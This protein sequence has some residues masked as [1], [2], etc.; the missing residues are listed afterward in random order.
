MILARAKTKQRFTIVFQVSKFV[1]KSLNFEH[2]RLFPS[3]SKSNT[4]NQNQVLKLFKITSEIESGNG[5]G[6]YSRGIQPH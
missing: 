6:A 3:D 2:C 5:H 4:L 1:A